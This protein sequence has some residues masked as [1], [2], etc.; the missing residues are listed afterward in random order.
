[1]SKEFVP[2][3]F[4]NNN[5]PSGKKKPCCVCDKEVGEGFCC[6]LGEFACSVE[7][8]SIREVEPDVQKALY[9]HDV[10][11]IDDAI[12]TMLLSVCSD[13][14]VAELAANDDDLISKIR[15]IIIEYF[16]DDL[17]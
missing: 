9:S 17:K 1:M 6:G 13:N 14:K 8:A 4:S 2:C 11:V 5:N 7:C 16:G 10:E 3:Y 15:S 12:T